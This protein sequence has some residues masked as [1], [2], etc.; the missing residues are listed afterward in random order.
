MMGKQLALK[1]LVTPLLYFERLLFPA[2]AAQVISPE[3]EMHVD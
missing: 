2:Y 1:Y 3:M